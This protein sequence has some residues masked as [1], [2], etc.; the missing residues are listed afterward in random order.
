MHNDIQRIFL[1][2]WE[3]EGW[4]DLSYEQIGQCLEANVVS[5]FNL[6][7]PRFYYGQFTPQGFSARR[8]HSRMKKASLAPTVSGRY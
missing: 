2:Y 3:V 4:T 8:K 5:G 7:D 1:P 6:F